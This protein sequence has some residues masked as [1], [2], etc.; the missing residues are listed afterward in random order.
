METTVSCLGFIQS[1]VGNHWKILRPGSK[2]LK[3]HSGCFMKNALQRFFV[4]SERSCVSR[5]SWCTCLG[6]SE[7]PSP[8]TSGK[9][10]IIPPLTQRGCPEHL[11][12]VR[13]CSGYWCAVSVGSAW[14]DFW[15]R[16]RGSECLLLYILPLLLYFLLLPSGAHDNGRIIAR[17]DE[18]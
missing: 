3:D 17:C 18:L 11:L 7:Q 2:M 5:V 14:L 13:N 16:G 12:F 9:E 8:L 1:A 10:Q 6:R 4:F 15:P